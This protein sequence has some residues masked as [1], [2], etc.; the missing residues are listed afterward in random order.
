MVCP[1]LITM[2][3]NRR[4]HERTQGIRA[5]KTFIE[6]KSAAANKVNTKKKKWC[7]MLES[8]RRIKYKSDKS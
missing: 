3:G 6:Y 7:Q 8:L 4:Y 1:S 2:H 5:I